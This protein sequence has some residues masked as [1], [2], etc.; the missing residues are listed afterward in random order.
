MSIEA[1]ELPRGTREAAE[2]VFKRGRVR[3]PTQSRLTALN[4]D[5][6]P[7]NDLIM[8]RHKVQQ[9]IQVV[10]GTENTKSRTLTDIRVL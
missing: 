6:E 8:H 7:V 3:L 4:E 5:F 10:L 2:R 9:E 1:R